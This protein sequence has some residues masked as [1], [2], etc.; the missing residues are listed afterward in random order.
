MKRVWRK[1]F[2]CW[3]IWKG[4]DQ[5]QAVK[6]A[7][8]TTAGLT[9]K[10]FLQ[11]RKD[12]QKHAF[13]KP[14]V[15]CQGQGVRGVRWPRPEAEAWSPVP[16]RTVRGTE[17]RRKPFLLCHRPFIPGLPLTPGKTP[18]LQSLREKFIN[19]KVSSFLTQT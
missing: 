18:H 16:G 13:S 6:K 15:I 1:M 5:V 11:K 12:E 2:P 17:Q 9:E 14:P 10:W 8:R 3:T 7:D 4:N 19:I